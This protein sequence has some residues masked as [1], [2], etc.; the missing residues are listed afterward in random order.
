MKTNKLPW[1]WVGDTDRKMSAV[2]DADGTVVCG[3]LVCQQNSREIIGSH[4]LIVEAVARL[5]AHGTG[6]EG[7]RR[8]NAW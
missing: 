7:H 6:Q 1:K 5:D 8:G 2:V 3:S 4:K